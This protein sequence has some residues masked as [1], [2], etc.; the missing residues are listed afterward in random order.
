MTLMRISQVRALSDVQVEFTLTTGEV[1]K[2]DLAG[3]SGRRRF[4]MAE[5]R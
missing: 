3:P 5:G 4:G 1:A 2:R